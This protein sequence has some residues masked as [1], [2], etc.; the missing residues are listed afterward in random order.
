MFNSRSGREGRARSGVV[1]LTA[2]PFKLGVNPI[3]RNLSASSFC[4]VSGRERVPAD[5]NRNGIGANPLTST[6][7]AYTRSGNRSAAHSVAMGSQGVHTSWLDR[8]PAR[9]HIEVELLA[10]AIGLPFFAH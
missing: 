6:S 8:S 10:I 1:L 2:I 4:A 5:L 3:G 9:L 7:Y